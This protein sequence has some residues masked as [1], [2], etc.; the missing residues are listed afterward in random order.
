MIYFMG[1]VY[2]QSSYNKLIGNDNLYSLETFYTLRSNPDKRMEEILQFSDLLIVDSGAFTFMN[3]GTNMTESDMDRYFEEYCDFIRKYK[4]NPKVI[5]FFELDVDRV[6]GVDKALEYLN[7]LTEITDK[8]IP[9]W[10]NTRPISFFYDMCKKYKRVAITQAI[11]S[12]VYPEQINLFINVAHKYGAHIHLL[13]FARFNQLQ[14]LNLNKDDSFDAVSYIMNGAFCN[15]KLMSSD[16]NKIYTYD[17]GDL[18]GLNVR[19]LHFLNN[20]Y[21]HKLQLKFRNWDNS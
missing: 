16:L 12:D 1:G 21:H 15:F 20:I 6:F 19:Y 18:E 8:I 2:A 5:G 11:L 7:K 14:Y 13:G 10:H 17:F 3:S 9:V 4:D